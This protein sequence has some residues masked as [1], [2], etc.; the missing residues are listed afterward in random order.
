MNDPSGGI[1]DADNQGGASEFTFYLFQKDDHRR[2]YELLFSSPAARGL[3]ERARGR[4][5]LV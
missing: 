3:Q 4:C 1:T 5:L 2:R